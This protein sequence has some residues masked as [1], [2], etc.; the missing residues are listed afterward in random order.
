MS[1]IDLPNG[2]LVTMDCWM[3]PLYHKGKQELYD[4]GAEK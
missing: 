2:S 1:T 3:K 4:K